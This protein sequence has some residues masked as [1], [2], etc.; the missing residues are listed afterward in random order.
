MIQ[1]TK[2]NGKELSE[3][4]TGYQYGIMERGMKAIG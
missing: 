4:D 3:K 2:D 1:Y